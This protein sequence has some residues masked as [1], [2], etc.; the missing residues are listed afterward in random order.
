[1]ASATV[2]FPAA[3]HHRPFTGTKLHCLVTEACVREQLAQ[4]CCLKAER[5]GVEPATSGVEVQRPN[6]YATRPPV[7]S[8]CSLSVPNE[9]HA[10]K[11]KPLKE[12]KK[13]S[14][15]M[16]VIRAA[17]FLFDCISAL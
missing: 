3:G 9:F 2:T 15:M 14:M 7:N 13:P 4:G 6:H 1:M 11:F 12:V 8:P 10:P 17:Y 5:P 16:P